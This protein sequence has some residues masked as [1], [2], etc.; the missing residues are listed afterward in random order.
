MGMLESTLT[1]VLIALVTA[2]LVQAGRL[3]K[4]L[5]E[6]RKGRLEMERFIYEFNATVIR[7]EASVKSLR[8]AAR[9]SGD[10]LEKL[11]NKAELVRDELDL[12]VGS[13]DQRAARLT[14]AAATAL[15]PEKAEARPASV[16][17]EAEPLPAVTSL[18][19]RKSEPAPSSRAEKELM[20]AIKKLS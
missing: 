8:Q 12:I 6:L 7:A 16:K 10:D 15:R 14:E 20:Q 1:I 18:P 2:G 9:D 4:H 5:S 17:T 19:P 13:A 3:I 11:V